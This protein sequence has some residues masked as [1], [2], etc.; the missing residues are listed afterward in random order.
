MVSPPQ[1]PVPLKYMYNANI[2]RSDFTTFVPSYTPMWHP[3]IRPK[4][5]FLKNSTENGML[6]N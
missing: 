2:L 1:M 5:P 4:L 3:I 6:T